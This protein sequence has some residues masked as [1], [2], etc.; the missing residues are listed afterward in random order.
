[1]T[2]NQNQYGQAPQQPQGY[3]QV[4][5]GNGQAPQAP[6]GYGQVP[7][8]PQPQQYPKRDTVVFGGTVTKDPELRQTHSGQTVLNLD[9]VMNSTRVENGSQFARV[10]FWEEKARM[11]A[12]FIKKGDRFTGVGERV[13]KEWTDDSGTTHRNLE[14]ERASIHLDLTQLVDLIRTEIKH[15]LHDAQAQPA[16]S[17]SDQ[18]QAQPQTPVQTQ[19]QP[20]PIPNAQPQVSEETPILSIDDDMLPF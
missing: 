5:Q 20:Q 13:W 1:M 12:Y 2:Y 14:Y 9:F 16:Q 19:P 4:P 17:Q 7:Q 15:A 3:G 8:R 10:T 18:P 11:V 6:Q